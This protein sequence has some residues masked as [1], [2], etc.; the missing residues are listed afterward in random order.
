MAYKQ[1]PGRGPMMKTGKGVPSAL[2]QV[3]PTD[4]IKKKKTCFWKS[5]IYI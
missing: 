3:D 1:N 5:S 2:L 4:P